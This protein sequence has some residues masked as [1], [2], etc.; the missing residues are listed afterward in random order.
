MEPL[1]ENRDLDAIIQKNSTG[2]FK[3]VLNLSKTTDPISYIFLNTEDLNNSFTLL[4]DKESETSLTGAQLTHQIGELMGNKTILIQGCYYGVVDNNKLLS[5]YRD[6]QPLYFSTV[7]RISLNIELGSIDNSKLS[8]LQLKISEEAEYQHLRELISAKLD[9][10]STGLYLERPLRK[11]IPAESEEPQGD[12]IKIIIKNIFASELQMIVDKT[13]TISSIL[14][15]L[16]AKTRI[17]SEKLELKLTDGTKLDPNQTIQH[18]NIQDGTTVILTFSVRGPSRLGRIV[19]SK[20]EKIKNLFIDGEK[21]V[22][23]ELPADYDTKMTV[24][25]KTLTEK[26]CT[27]ETNIH[28]S[29]GSVKQLIEP[30]DKGA[31][32]LV[33]NGVQLPLSDTLF[34]YGITE[35]DI[36]LPAIR[37]RG[38]FGAE[39]L[40][41]PEKEGASEVELSKEPGL[42]YRA[43]T[44]G[45]CIEGVCKTA[46]CKAF[47]KNVVVN[48]GYISFDSKADAGMSECPLCKQYVTP[49]KYA[50]NRCTLV[51]VEIHV[52]KDGVVKRKANQKCTAY[53]ES[54]RYIEYEKDSR[55]K[56][57]VMGYYSANVEAMKCAV[58]AKN[59]ENSS[60]KLGCGHVYHTPCLQTIGEKLTSN[61]LLCHY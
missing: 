35:E 51:T 33:L 45:L 4:V 8:T 1:Q 39:Q 15:R 41:V 54:Y 44:G 37:S 34:E 14:D 60:E 7:S 27:S 10:S 29:I 43:A 6:S 13:A 58:C 26:M 30:E 24:K 20:T 61:C 48:L 40:Q 21:L 59:I 28:A 47:E 42:E 19:G 57:H 55:I 52:T 18:Y 36:L 5:Y 9:K 23:W 50:V 46:N 32:L 12:Q 2:E 31:I 16:E 49:V 17:F 25:Y 38:P 56:I 3:K 53:K 22:L 11:Q